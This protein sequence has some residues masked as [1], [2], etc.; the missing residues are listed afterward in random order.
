MV[1]LQL[2][3]SKQVAGGDRNITRSGRTGPG[4]SENAGPLVKSYQEFQDGSRRAFNVVDPAECV[5]LRTPQVT[6]PG[7]GVV[8]GV[9]VQIPA[10]PLIN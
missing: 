2:D 1:R 10:Q 5:V 3:Q 8:G 4:Q 7:A 6:S 9:W